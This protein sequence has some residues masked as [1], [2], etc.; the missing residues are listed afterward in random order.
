MLCLNDMQIQSISLSFFEKY[1][2]SGS[3][4][5]P[6]IG[7][8][9]RVRWCVVSFCVCLI[10][11]DMRFLLLE[12]YYSSRLIQNIIFCH[13]AS[14]PCQGCVLWLTNTKSILMF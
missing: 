4:V 11:C 10:F 9:I 1:I 7:G 12:K 13:L 2:A 5:F 6:V 8:N 3:G 14:A